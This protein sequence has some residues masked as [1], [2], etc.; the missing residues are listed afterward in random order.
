VPDAVPGPRHTPVRVLLADDHAL[1]RA[2]LAS[3]LD[4]TEDVTVVGQAG[5]GAAAV[6]LARETEPDVVLMD[7]SMPVLDG[8]EATRRL[9]AEAPG[10]RVLVLTSFSDRERVHDALDAGAIGY[11]LKDADPRDLVAA[12]RAAARGDA[13][14]DPRVARALLPG[15]SRPGHPSPLG[16]ASPLSPRERQ[17]LRLVARGMANKQIGRALGITERTVK[18]HLGNAFRRI[19]VS[20]RT[21]AA[22]W[23]REHL[24][25]E[26][27]DGAGRPAW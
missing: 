21:S 5:D 11:L 25:S 1:V 14:L 24:P 23:A 26:D 13:P 17:V 7:L 2:G 10:T 20:D 8:V 15:G 22:L 19:G 27:S 6:E 16:L 3:L 9:L 4:E 18:V 12:I